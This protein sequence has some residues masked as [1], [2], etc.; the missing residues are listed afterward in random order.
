MLLICIFEYIECDSYWNVHV[1]VRISDG[2]SIAGLVVVFFIGII[3]GG[4]L[5]NEKKAGWDRTSNGAYV[6]TGE[7][8]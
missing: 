2:L 3:E 6:V 5:M 4:I 8:V 1:I 7:L